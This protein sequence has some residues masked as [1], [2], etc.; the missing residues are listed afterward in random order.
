MRKG[1]HISVEAA[2]TSI[3]LAVETEFSLFRGALSML[4]GRDSVRNRGVRRMKRRDA[5]VF[6]RSQTARLTHPRA[7][8]AVCLY[9]YAVQNALTCTQDELRKFHGFSGTFTSLAIKE[10]R[11][12]LLSDPDYLKRYNAVRDRLRSKHWYV[13]LTEG[14]RL[15]AQ[16]WAQKMHDRLTKLSRMPLPPEAGG[17][18]REALTSPWQASDPM[19]ELDRFESAGLP[20]EGYSYPEPPAIGVSSKP[21]ASP[22]APIAPTTPATST[23]LP[24]SPEPLPGTSPTCSDP[25]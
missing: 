18:V 11:E 16:E 5:T 2:V 19:S 22:K 4:K 6:I 1:E 3:R 12:R 23:R 7:R 9:L 17:L 10:A 13:Q 25:A 20:P 15:F 24:D 8:A 14:R 21:E